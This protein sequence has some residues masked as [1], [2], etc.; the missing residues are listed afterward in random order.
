MLRIECMNR[1]INQLRS[2]H[3]K[4]S[5]FLVAASTVHPAGVVVASTMFTITGY[6][7]EQFGALFAV[8]ACQCL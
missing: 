8:L 4:F 7:N 2:S 3:T 5:V 1:Q 6:A